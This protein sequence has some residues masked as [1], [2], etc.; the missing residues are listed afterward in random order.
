MRWYFVA[1]FIQLLK[2]WFCMYGRHCHGEELGSF[3]W[4]SQLLALQ[5]LVHLTYLLSVLLRCTGFAR[6]Q[7]AVVDQTGIRPPNSAHD[8]FWCKSG[9]GKCFICLLRNLYAGHKATVRTGHGTMDWFQIGKGVRQGCILSPCL[10]NLYAEY[11]MKNAKM[12]EAQTG[13]RFPGEIWITS[14]TWMT[15]PLW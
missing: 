4:P 6:I 11:I 14:D 8:F 10:F 13:I 7:K 15:L 2:H 12:D 5:F 9:F 1:Q 3:Y